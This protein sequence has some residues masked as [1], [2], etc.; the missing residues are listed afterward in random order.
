MFGR[1]TEA[2]SALLT[3]MHDQ[4]REQ[5]RYNQPLMAKTMAQWMADDRRFDSI[6]DKERFANEVMD[7][8]QHGRQ[9]DLTQRMGSGANAPVGYVHRR[10]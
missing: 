2:I 9:L 10:V 3:R 5:C 8:R 6:A 1:D 4:A 7:C